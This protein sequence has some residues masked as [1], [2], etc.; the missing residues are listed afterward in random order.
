[1]VIMRP[2]EEGES[3][4]RAFLR[5]TLERLTPERRRRLYDELT[6]ARDEG[7]N[8]EITAPSEDQP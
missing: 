1:M 4:V 8:H 7:R 6:R 5:K 3:R 2:T